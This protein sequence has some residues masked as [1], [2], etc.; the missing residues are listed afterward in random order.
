M[1]RCFSFCLL[2]LSISVPFIEATSQTFALDAAK[3]YPLE[4]GN[5]WHYETG[6]RFRSYILSTT[7]DT[8]VQDVQ[9]TKLSV[10]EYNGPGGSPRDAWRRLTDDFYVL[11]TTDFIR[12]DTLWTTQ[13]RSIFSVNIPYDGSLQSRYA[14]TGST[15]RAGYADVYLDTTR[16]GEEMRLHLFAG[17][18]FNGEVFCGKFIYEV[19]YA[20]DCSSPGLNFVGTIVNG[21]SIGE[22]SR[23]VSLVGLEDLGPETRHLPK[24][25]FYPNPFREQINIE[26]S[27]IKQ[28][29]YNITIFD[30][31]GRVVFSENR[32]LVNGQVWKR[33]W[34][35][36]EHLTGGVYF[37]HVIAD[38]GE[39]NTASILL[40][41]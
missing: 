12:E 19:G 34:K 31:L 30:V 9:W 22:T 15:Q 6:D 36:G 39:R 38:S 27:A 7:T 1:K 10:L 37:L 16:V 5:Y 24:N 2:F 8:L 29:V 21:H 35:P 26:L 4:T 18:G 33:T 20:G 23:I 41:P 11:S 14:V 13:P 3:W 28:G 32:V 40:L 25:S 17:L